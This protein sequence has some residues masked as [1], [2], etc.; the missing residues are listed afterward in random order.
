MAMAMKML[1]AVNPMRGKPKQAEEPSDGNKQQLASQA[2]DKFCESVNAKGKAAIL[3][4]R[5]N[6]SQKKILEGV[7]KNYDEY[8]AIIAE[9]KQQERPVERVEAAG[10][11]A[12]VPTPPMPSPPPQSLSTAVGATVPTPPMPSP[13]PQSL[14]TAVNWD[15]QLD[16]HGGGSGGRRRTKNAKYYNK[17]RR[18]KRRRTKRRR[19]NKRRA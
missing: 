11:G 19:S 13:P 12:T 6:G 17:R 14:S 9:L 4:A 8:D 5:L 18:T 1:N 7:F 2:V 16:E 10:V 15:G 3:A